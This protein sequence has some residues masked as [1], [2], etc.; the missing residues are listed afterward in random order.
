MPMSPS[1]CCTKNVVLNPMNV[2]QKCSLP[3]RSSSNLPV[4]F[5][6]QK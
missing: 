3:S 1:Q 4:I 2:N 5:G 6:N